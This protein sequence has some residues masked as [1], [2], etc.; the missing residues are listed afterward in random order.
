MY[1]L[2]EYNGRP[3]DATYPG[4][5][6]AGRP[7]DDAVPRRSFSCGDI[8]RNGKRDGED[9][10]RSWGEYATL[11]IWSRKISIVEDEERLGHG[12][13]RMPHD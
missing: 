3:Q 5:L 10:Q 12:W 2:L 9:K 11:T 4:K 1:Y 13:K 6:F 7:N 8:L